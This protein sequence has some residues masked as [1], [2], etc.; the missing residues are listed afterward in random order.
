MPLPENAPWPDLIP[1]FLADQSLVGLY[2]IQNRRFTY[3]NE[4]FAQV[5]G[6]TVDEILEMP[7]V[8]GVVAPTAR[9]KVG[10]NIERRISGQ[11]DQIHYVTEGIHKNGSTLYTEVHGMRLETADGP[12]I[13]GILIDRTSGVEAE[14]RALHLQKLEAA[15]LLAAGIAHDF[16]NVLLGIRGMAEL[17]RSDGAGVPREQLVD[18][19]VAAVEQGAS[20]SSQLMTLNL[21]KP[22]DVVPVSIAHHVDRM[23][24]FLARL[25]SKRLQ[26]DVELA[27]DLPLLPV[28]PVHI[29]QIVMNLV[30]NAVDATPPGGRIVVS[31]RAEA[32]DPATEASVCLAVRDTGA[33]IPKDVMDRVF[34]PY[35]TTKADKGTGLGLANVRA[36]AER[37]GGRA[38]IESAP[39]AG[40]TVSVWIPSPA[41]H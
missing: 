13:V 2:V 10:E 34:E 16:R 40:T 41:A 35:F 6:Y 37:Y 14:R 5:F 21:Q 25:L 23:R 15:G 12:A 27:P 39:G 19:I 11:T 31:V 26:M 22:T 9:A 20:L 18:E 32:P 33:G 29:E 36:I 24:P 38:S 8:D 17:I 7:S 1:R 28:D 3:A 4:K 30:I